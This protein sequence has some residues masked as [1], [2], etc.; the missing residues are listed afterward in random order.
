MV[1]SRRREVILEIEH[2]KVVR[3]RAKSSLLFCRDCGR[4]TDFISL[5]QA[6]DLFAVT[7]GELFEFSR[8]NLCHVRFEQRRKVFLCLAD[9]LNAMSNKLKKGK[10]RLL[11]E[12]NHETGSPQ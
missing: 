11:G 12:S 5:T 9:L 7:P 4:T 8:S 10:V 6:A 2:L 3:K 1:S